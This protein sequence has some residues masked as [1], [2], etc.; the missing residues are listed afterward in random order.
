MKI[1]GM[2][3]CLQAITSSLTASL[4]LADSALLYDN[5]PVLG[6]T[7]WGI[8][9]YTT[10]DSFSVSAAV[11][12]TF[13]QAYTHAATGRTPTNVDWRI[14]TTPGGAEIS[15]GSANL[16]D[17]YL[18]GSVHES[19]FEISGN[20]AAAGTYYLTLTGSRTDV[21]GWDTYWWE[22][23]GP[24]TAYQMDYGWRIPSEAFRLYG[25]AVCKDQ[26]L[27]NDPGQ[28][29]AT[30]TF[31]ALATTNWPGYVVTV[32]PPPRSFLPVGTNVVAWTAVDAVSGQLSNTCTFLVAVRDCEPPVI[33][34][35]IANPASLWPP[36]HKMQPVVLSVS[37]IDN[38][39]VAHSRIVSVSS[40]GAANSD[41]EITGDLTLKLRSER[42]GN[43][44]R[45]YSITVESSDDSGNRSFAVVTVAVQR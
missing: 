5:G 27:C 11:M 28:C 29:G 17:N 26:T 21:G 40:D 41:W 16:S 33:H 7:S 44:P 39:H 15:S 2:F 4:A 24:S 1:Q 10:S 34:D 20:L 12:L 30:V 45:T 35:V 18:G 22:S 32:D 43:T 13:A 9:G 42:S 14:G 3:W 25:E 8:G 37:A 36:N 23:G 6:G 19:N 31:G 38:C